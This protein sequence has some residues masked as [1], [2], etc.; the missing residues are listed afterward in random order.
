MCALCLL[1]AQPTVAFA[2]PSQLKV[3]EDLTLKEAVSDVLC[4]CWAYVKSKIPSFPNTQ[5]IIL[6]QGQSHNGDVVVFDYPHYGIQ[7]NSNDEGFWIEDANW[8]GCG[9][10]THFIEWDNPHI[11]GHWTPEDI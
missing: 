2:P 5:E 8:G 6:K 9:T 4:N 7:V 10:Q 11:I 3:T 1:V